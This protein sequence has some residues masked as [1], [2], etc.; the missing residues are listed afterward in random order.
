MWRRT[1]S[2]T[3]CRQGD[4]DGCGRRPARRTG[5]GGRPRPPRAPRVRAAGR[6]PPCRP[7]RP[8]AG[9]C[10]GS[11]ARRGCVGGPGRLPDGRVPREVAV[12]LGHL[13]H[14]VGRTGRRRGVEH[15]VR[16]LPRL[17]ELEPFPGLLLHVCRVTPSLALRLERGHVLLLLG[18]RVPERRG[19]PSR[20]PRRRTACAPGGHRSG[21]P[22][23]RRAKRGKA[24]A[25]AY[26]AASSSS[27]SIR[28]SWL[29]L[30]TRSDRAG[31]PV[32]IWPALVATTRSAIVTSS[33]SP[34]RCEMIAVY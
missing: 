29:Y 30:A 3:G 6:P 2:G 28:S 19:R 9:R 14:R 22:C 15:G 18:H 16:P 31:A 13:G 8:A 17:D 25:P 21:Q 7:A 1:T 23:C 33:V 12:G 11:S 26:T 24:A 10:G 32:L 27:S 4:A 5:T 20:R 34:E